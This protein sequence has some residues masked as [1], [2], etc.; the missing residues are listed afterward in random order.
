MLI[1]MLVIICHSMRAIYNCICKRSC[2]VSHDVYNTLR[3]I[4]EPSC[5]SSSVCSH[6]RNL[7]VLLLFNVAH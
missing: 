4:Y 7:P 6:E 1:V 2:H 3:T 5:A